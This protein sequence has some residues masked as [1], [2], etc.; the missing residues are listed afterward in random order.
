MTVPIMGFDLSVRA[1][2]LALTDGTCRTIRP[3]NKPTPPS[4]RLHELVHRIGARIDAQPP[5]VAVIEGYGYN[6]ARMV[7]NVELGG[8]VR[9]LLHARRIPYIE[10]APNSLKLWATGNG[11][12]TKDDMIAAARANGG[13]IRNDDEAD[14]YLLRLAGLARYEPADRPL[15]T[16]TLLRLPWPELNRTA[17]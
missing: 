4:A 15:L 17:A 10:I 6:S 9:L 13:E 5:A 2:G 7:R 14:A 11:H 12:A 16:P 1:T 8:A 3:V